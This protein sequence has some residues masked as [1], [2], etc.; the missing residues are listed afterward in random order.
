MKFATDLTKGILGSADSAELW[1]K[2]IAKIPNSVLTKPNV[3]ILVVACG[4]GTEAVILA[5]RML[6]LGVSKA[7]VNKSIWL[8]DKYQVFTNHAKLVYGFKN[9]I[10]ED[11]LKWNS[12][13][14]FNV[15]VGNPPFQD[16]DSGNEKSNLY[17]EF[18]RKSIE[19]HLANDGH[20]IF[21]TPKTML[22]KTKRYFSLVG[23]SG[24]KSVD[25]TANDYF[26]V[27]VD[28]VSWHVNKGKNFNQ[29]TVTNKDQSV[30]SIPAGEE[31]ADANELW[32]YR[33]VENMKNN[34]DKAF[35][36][37]NIGPTRSKVKTKEYCYQLKQN[38]AKNSVVYSKREPYHHGK[39]KL[40]ISVSLGYNKDNVVVDTADY[41][42][43]YVC[44]DITK[45]TKVQ[46]NNI[47]SFLFNDTFVA[48]VAKYRLIYKTG[49]ANILVYLPKFDIN[50]SW[51]DKDI[52]KFFGLTKDDV[53]KLN[54]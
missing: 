8:I 38:L 34:P 17:V 10:T 42:E 53:K 18:A 3:R 15:I 33:L 7:Q 29:V 52:I 21:L 1:T 45:V 13:M 41:A 46:Y 27:G 39:K 51:T 49:F 26:N 40:L 43:A 36:Y 12:D 48:L 32:L 9:V 2:S 54:A 35:S 24:L 37:N 16:S 19:Q 6:A 20:I 25:F 30:T 5:R 50:K 44:M 22:R 4:H 31:I 11:Y 23:Q 28:I 14:K 47:M